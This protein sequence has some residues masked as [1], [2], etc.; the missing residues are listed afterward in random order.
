MTTANQ[1]NNCN[2]QNIVYQYKELSLDSFFN[3]KMNINTPNFNRALDLTSTCE[4]FSDGFLDVQNK[5]SIMIKFDANSIGETL[6]KI[7]LAIRCY[8]KPSE[9]DEIKSWEGDFC[10]GNY[11]PIID[12]NEKEIT[13]DISDPKW[14]QQ[15]E[16]K[17]YG[18]IAIFYDHQPNIEKLPDHIIKFGADN[19]R[20]YD[21]DQLGKILLKSA[22]IPPEVLANI[23]PGIS[24]IR[25]HYA[26]SAYVYPMGSMIIPAKWKSYQSIIQCE[27]KYNGA[28]SCLRVGTKF[29][30]IGFL[31]NHGQQNESPELLIKNFHIFTK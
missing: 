30:K 10:S 5:K 6:S 8:Q 27:G 1:N 14:F 13:V 9:S 7:Y 25:Y 15:F 26:S 17:A 31:V 3:I 23:Q 4:L 22:V 20:D 18:C 21:I 19:Q 16:T 12:C 28:G 29:I 2:D 24:H 11:I